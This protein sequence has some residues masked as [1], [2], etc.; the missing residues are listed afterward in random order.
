MGDWVS[1]SP[2]FSA[3]NL[4]STEF[5]DYVGVGYGS[6]PVDPSDPT[7]NTHF[8]VPIGMTDAQNQTW[9][10][11]LG[12]F[13]EEFAQGAPLNTARITAV[14]EPGSLALLAGLGITGT[15]FLVSRRRARK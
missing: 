5:T 6:G 10:L 13:D 9:A 11:T 3:A 8:I 7:G 15:G 1:A 14:P 2:T 4:V 12:N